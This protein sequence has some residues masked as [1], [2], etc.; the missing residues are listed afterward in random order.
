MAFGAGLNRSGDGIKDESAFGKFSNVSKLLLVSKTLDEI[1]R[2]N[3]G[4]LHDG[5]INVMFDCTMRFS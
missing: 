3:E 4:T 1:F 2:K 5:Q